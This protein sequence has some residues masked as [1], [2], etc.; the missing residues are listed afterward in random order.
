MTAQV[1]NGGGG[2]YLVS[3]RILKVI[4]PQ[5]ALVGTYTSVATIAVISG[6]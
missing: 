2:T 3:P 4:V 6:P 1:L 5:N